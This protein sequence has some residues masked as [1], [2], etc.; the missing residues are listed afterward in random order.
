[1]KEGTSAVLLQSGLD[2]EWWADS[3]GCYCY[4]RNIQDLW[5]DGKTPY[6]R[7]FGMPF[8]EPD[9]PFGAM[10]EYHPISAKEPSRL[11]QLVLKSCQVYSSVMCCPPGESGKETQWS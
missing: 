11:H 1:M 5:P 3:L 7:R 8:N 10:V 2:N 6:E 4:L 9:I